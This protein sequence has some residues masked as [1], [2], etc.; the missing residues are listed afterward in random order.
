MTIHVCFNQTYH[1][2]KS[3]IK[4]K[5]LAM[6]EFDSLAYIECVIKISSWHNKQYCSHFEKAKMGL[7]RF[8]GFISPSYLLWLFGGYCKRQRSL[9]VCN[10]IYTI[11]V[12]KTKDL[13]KKLFNMFVIVHQY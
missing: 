3:C 10:N 7:K 4:K 9:R 8:F 5:G 11:F 13:H 6:A 2:N 1:L 12:F